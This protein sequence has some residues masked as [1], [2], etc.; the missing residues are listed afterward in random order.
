MHILNKKI[1]EVFETNNTARDM[2][3]PQEKES[4]NKCFCCGGVTN[5]K[6]GTINGNLTG[7]FTI[8]SMY[9][10]ADIFILY[11]IRKETTIATSKNNIKYLTKQGFKLVINIIGNVASKEI[12]S[13]L[14]EN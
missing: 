3:S 11:D 8:H 12:Q 1:N 6:Y 13:Y 14:K 2:H 4:K 7:K 9:V 5:N 10:M